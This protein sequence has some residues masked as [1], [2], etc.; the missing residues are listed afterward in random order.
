[1][2][3][4]IQIEGLAELV[5]KLEQ[6]GK[7]AVPL[8]KE[9]MATATLEI[10]TKA[11][12]AC[13]VDKGELRRSIESEVEVSGNVITGVVGTNKEYAP[14]VEY[15]T[16]L[17][18]TKGSGRKTPWSYQD[19]EGNWHTTT[20]QA[21]QPYLAPAVDAERVKEIMVKKGQEVLEK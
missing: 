20:G 9:G 8:I 16:G 4:A 21:P 6:A 3:D 13:P 17:F 5:K 10:E 15:G 11:K 18:S 2:G 7:N 12:E 14:Y 19:A 1:M